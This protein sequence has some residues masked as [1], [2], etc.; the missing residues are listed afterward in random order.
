MNELVNV[1]DMIW[2]FSFNDLIVFGFVGSLGMFFLFFNMV[3]MWD[4]DG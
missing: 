1:F 2:L 3:V 4:M